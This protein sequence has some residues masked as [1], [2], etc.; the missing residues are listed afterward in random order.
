MI[1]P[2][3]LHELRFFSGLRNVIVG[4]YKFICCSAVLLLLIYEQVSV[5]LKCLHLSHLRALGKI[6]ACHWSHQE[7]EGGRKDLTTLMYYSLFF[8]GFQKNLCSLLIYM[9]DPQSTKE[10]QVLFSLPQAPQMRIELIMMH[11]F[12]H[13]PQ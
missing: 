6:C 1:W 2:R 10:E 11:Y 7:I 12:Q 4:E 3:N 13:K 8:H 5:P 9:S